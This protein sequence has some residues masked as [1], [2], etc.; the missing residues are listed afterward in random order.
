MHLYTM[1]RHVKS[2]EII[3]FGYEK[4]TDGFNGAKSEYCMIK[5]EDS[6]S[7]APITRHCAES[8]GLQAGRRRRPQPAG[9]L[10]RIDGTS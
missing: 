9:L 5:A 10:G 3:E 1:C 8:S 4:S 2:I 6:T 7:S